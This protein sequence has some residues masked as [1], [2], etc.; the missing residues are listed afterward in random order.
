MKLIEQIIYYYYYYFFS[1]NLFGLQVVLH[2][3][4]C[5]C[6]AFVL[7]RHLISFVVFLRFFLDKLAVSD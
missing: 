5:N 2:L 7:F 3:S 4:H 1:I 6:K